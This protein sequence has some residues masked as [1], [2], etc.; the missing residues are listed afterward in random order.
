LRVLITPDWYPWPDQPLF[1]VF[2]REQARAVARLVDVAVLTWRVD[3]D[4]R[5]PFR[6]EVADE[7]GLTTL[8][9]RVAHGRV[10]RSTFGFKLVG[11]LMALATLRQRGWVPDVLHAHEY[12]AA[13]VALALGAVAR[14]PA[15][16][17]EH[18][19][20]FALGTLPE[21]ERRR[22]KWAFEHGRLVCP[23]SRNLAGYVQAIAP[24]AK[25]EPVPNVVDTDVFAPDGTAHDAAPPRL[26][27]VGS[28]VEIKGHRHLVT[29]LARLRTAGRSMRLDVVGD[30]P[31]RAELEKLAADVGVTDLIVFHGVKDKAA[32]AAALRQADVFVLPSLWENL[33]CALLEAMSAGLPV[34]ATSVGGVPE[35]VDSWQAIL[36]E[37]GSP[38]ALADGLRKMAETVATYDR[39]RLR[40][41]VVAGFGYDAIGRRWADVYGSVTGMPAIR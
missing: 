23:V 37:A 15:I 4:L 1:G 6:L 9:L 12:G 5:V 27:T 3:P 40:A 36:V 10:P 31:L 2:C 19:S 11:S 21:R 22:A 32:V 30:G 26:I 7:D 17:S 35:V 25:I 8:R 16:I 34:V 28:L 14:A 13:P 24:R 41:S 29:A 20:G 38:D 33:P 18:Y 39:D